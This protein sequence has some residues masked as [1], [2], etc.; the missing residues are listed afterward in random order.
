[1]SIGTIF[2]IYK[3]VTPVGS[4][5]VLEDFLQPGKNQVAAGYVI[6]GSST[7]LVYTTGN[8]VNGFTLDPT[9]GSYFLSHP[10]MKIPVDGSIY[11]VNEGNYPFFAQGLKDYLRHIK[12]VDA[13]QNT[14]YSSRY[15]G[16]LVSYIHR[17]ILKGGIYMYPGTTL[18]PRGKLRLCYECNPCLLYT[19]PSPRD[20]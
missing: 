12:Q 16:S 20:S 19:S 9:I 4:K 7:M 17:N 10:D 3:R 18:K 15:I 5:A 13:K 8:G 2:S 6:Y 11:S 14:P 1:M